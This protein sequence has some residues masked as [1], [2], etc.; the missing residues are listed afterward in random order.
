MQTYALLLPLVPEP[1][2]EPHSEV[3]DVVFS[4]DV[5][6]E[7]HANIPMSSV[8]DAIFPSVNSNVP[9][10]VAN[11]P[12]TLK[13]PKS[14]TSSRTLSKKELKEKKFFKT[15]PLTRRV[16]TPNTDVEKKINAETAKKNVLVSRIKILKERYGPLLYK[17][18]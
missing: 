13:P 5:N 17:S 11:K 7:E 9:K 18:Q 4:I 16:Y 2:P 6:P 12:K 14:S 3:I 1:I 10:G 15:Q 8:S